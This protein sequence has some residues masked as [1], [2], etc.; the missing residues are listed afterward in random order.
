MQDAIT[1]TTDFKVLKDT[2]LVVEAVFE[3]MKV[4]RDLFERLEGIVHPNT[5]LAT[6]TSSFLV[7]E[8]AK[9]MTHPERA[10][11]L[12]FFYHPVKNRLLEVIPTEITSRETL[13][14]A[15][16]LCTLQGKVELLCG[17]TPGFVVNRFFVPW[18]NEAVRLLAEGVAPLEV[19]ES[20]AKQGFRLGMG[21]F[22]LMNVTGV[23]IACHAAAG[24]A[25]PLGDFYA[26]DP[27]LKTQVEKGRW[28]I[29][30][31]EEF[32]QPVFDRLLATVWAVCGT[33][34]KD[35]SAT[36]L[37]ID[38]GARVGLRW[39]TGPFGLFNRL[40]PEDRKRALNA[41]SNRH[42]DYPLPEDLQT[43]SSF[44]V[45]TVE[46]ESDGQHAVISLARPDRSNALNGQV[47]SD[48]DGVLEANSGARA[49]VLKGKGKSL[50]AGADVRFFIKCMEEGKVDKIVD[51]TAFAQS[52][53]SK[54]DGFPGKAISVADGFALGGG[55][56]LMLSADVIVATPRATIGFPETGIGIYPGLGGTHRLTRRVGRGLAKYLIGTGQMIPG[57][58]AAE[59]GLADH[60]LP[61]EKLD[62]SGLAELEQSGKRELSGK[63]GDIADFMESH[64]LDQLLTGEFSED[65]QQKVQHKLHQKAPIALKLAWKLIEEN[66]NLTTE[67]ALKNELAHLTEVFTTSD[68]MEGLKSIGKYR[69]KFQGK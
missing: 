62:P 5:V 55:A 6:N 4:K 69:P 16:S 31:C 28:D 10:V 66:E 2:D 64:T 59:I 37:A 68:A 30:E 54:I 20:T 44:A 58:T 15:R 24:L 39:P 22:Q 46:A 1:L 56:E 50:A 65:W 48:L 47:F 12:H 23:P 53:T 11:G 14:M 7:S 52:V 41:F 19:I 9:E 35:G 45:P 26:P 49:I 25:E 43:A 42:P 34:V 38:L 63:W 32:S 29:P 67:Q 51:F 18:L 8:I 61:P 21:P 17:D 36:P 60:C 33:L 27:L 57:T 40:S 3:D 13:G